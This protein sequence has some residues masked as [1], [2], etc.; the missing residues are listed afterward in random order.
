MHLDV[1]DMDDYI[2][3]WDV[4]VDTELYLPNSL[5]V[6]RQEATTITVYL[7]QAAINLRR[8]WTRV[9]ARYYKETK[10]TK[11]TSSVVPSRPK[12]RPDLDLS[13]FKTHKDLPHRS[14]WQFKDRRFLRSK[15]HLSW[16]DRIR[17]Y[18]LSSWR[19]CLARTLVGLTLNVKKRRYK[20]NS[21]IPSFSRS[22]LHFQSFIHLRCI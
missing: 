18:V 6:S 11:T 3:V 10:K 1:I 16:V 5:E 19:I 2:W 14:S 8:G 4:H 17:L 20:P 21:S 15:S 12:S 7:C 9:I 13:I 22:L